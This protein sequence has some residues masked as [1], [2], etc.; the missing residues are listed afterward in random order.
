YT[1]E[2]AKG[3]DSNIFVA[4]LA[5]G[6]STLLTPHEGEQLFRANDF[7]P[8]GKKL[9]ITSNLASGYNNAGLL[10]VSSKK[11]GWAHEKEMGDS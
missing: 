10:D 8:D 9:L 4:E 5:S 3:T 6:K 1:Q 2:Q 7:S 11:I